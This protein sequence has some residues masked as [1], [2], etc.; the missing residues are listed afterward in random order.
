MDSSRDTEVNK[1]EIR[2]IWADV[3]TQ[4]LNTTVLPCKVLCSLELLSS[5][6]NFGF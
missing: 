4:S 2:E 3:I 6:V 5:S 1:V